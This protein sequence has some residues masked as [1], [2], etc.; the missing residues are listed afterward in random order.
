[1]RRSILWFRN[2]LR[3]H[4]NEALVDAL[5][6]NDEVVPLYVLDPRIFRGHTD[7]GFRKA[8]SFRVNFILESLIDLRTNLRE[9]GSDLIIRQGHPEEIVPQI[10][11]ELRTAYVYCNILALI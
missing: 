7:Y 8:S 4:D 5:A 2:D 9:R 11:R 6:H 10:A 1:M 3:L